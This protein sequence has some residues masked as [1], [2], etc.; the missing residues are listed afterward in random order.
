VFSPLLLIFN[1][2]FFG[3]LWRACRGRQKKKEAK[4]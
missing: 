3:G 4:L 2:S 1:L